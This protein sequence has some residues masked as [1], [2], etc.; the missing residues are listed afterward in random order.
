MRIDLID[1]FPD[2]VAELRALLLESPDSHLAQQP[3][4]LTVVDRCRCGDDFC[5]MFS[6]FGTAPCE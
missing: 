2:F 6:D 5:G 1:L 3:G 4:K